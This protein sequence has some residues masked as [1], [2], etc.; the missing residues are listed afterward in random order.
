MLP[1]NQQLRPCGAAGTG[2]YAELKINLKLPVLQARPD[3]GPELTALLNGA[4]GLAV[5][6]LVILSPAPGVLSRPKPEEEDLVQ[7][8]VIRFQR[9][10]SRRDAGCPAAAVWRHAFPE[11]AERG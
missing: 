1:K 8:P 4:H 6:K 3:A 7:I 10:D 9:V 5:E 11:A 2:L